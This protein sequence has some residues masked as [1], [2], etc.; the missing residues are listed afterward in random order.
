M[1]GLLQRLFQMMPLGLPAAFLALYARWCGW[2]MHIGIS[3]FFSYL[4]AAMLYTYS[5]VKLGPE[6]TCWIC[7]YGML[8]CTYGPK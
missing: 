5:M 8:R 2:E 6:I 3:F 4:F 7:V 1:S